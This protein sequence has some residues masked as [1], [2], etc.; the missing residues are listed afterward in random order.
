M[1][2][3][4]YYIVYWLYNKRYTTRNY[5]TEQEAKEKVKELK[6]QYDNWL[7]KEPQIYEYGY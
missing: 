4:E 1:E 3:L 6:R 2:H 7:S 5:L